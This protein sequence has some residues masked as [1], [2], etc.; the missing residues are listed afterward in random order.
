MLDL[1]AITNPE[2]SLAPSTDSMVSRN[3]VNLFCEPIS[4][5]VDTLQIMDKYLNTLHTLMSAKENIDGL[6]QPLSHTGGKMLNN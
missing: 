5:G 4:C 3:A 2:M 6:G 1:W